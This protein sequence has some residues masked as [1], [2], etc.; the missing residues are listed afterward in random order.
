[1]VNGLHWA[2]A[3][4]WTQQVLCRLTNKR[5]LLAFAH[6]DESTDGL[7][8]GVAQDGVQ[9]S[10]GEHANHSFALAL[11]FGRQNMA[12]LLKQFNHSPLKK[13]EIQ[14][15]LSVHPVSWRCCHGGSLHVSVWHTMRYFVHSR[16]RVSLHS[17]RVA[18]LSP[19]FRQQ[20]LQ[21]LDEKN[22]EGAMCC[23]LYL[24]D[25]HRHQRE[26]SPKKIN[27]QPSYI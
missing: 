3:S 16:V 11:E 18:H 20:V 2:R 12:N 6:V 8:G 23:G 25:R 27:L 10:L 1:M 17:M 14:I 13:E 22:A 19:F 21:S 4:G 24:I 15:K 9:H 26:G 7:R 5:S